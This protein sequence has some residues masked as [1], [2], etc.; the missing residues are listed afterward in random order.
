M[1]VSLLMVSVL[2]Q[3][4]WRPQGSWDHKQGGLTLVRAPVKNESMTV[5]SWPSIM[6]RST[7][8]EPTKPVDSRGQFKWLRS[9]DAFVEP[10]EASKRG[11]SET[12]RGRARGSG[13]SGRGEGTH[14]HRR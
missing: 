1:Q 4:L 11:S 13:E 5:T 9:E 7:R 2:K 3:R 6:S 10:P 8:C 14:R 12:R